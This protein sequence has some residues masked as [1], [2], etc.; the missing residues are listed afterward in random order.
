MTRPLFRIIFWVT[1]IVV[2]NACT[3]NHER[4]PGLK[5]E[6]GKEARFLI[7]GANALYPLA[8]IWA[9]AYQAEH[10]A[11]R[12]TVFPASSTKGITD[13]RMGLAEIGMYSNPLTDLSDDSLIV[14]K[15]AKDAVIPTMNSRNPDMVV[16]MNR[17]ITPDEF[18]DIFITGRI[19]QWDQ[20]TLSD[21]R[22]P[23]VV[24]TRSD[25]SGAAAVWAEFLGASQEK[26]SGIGVYGDAGM[27]QA[28]RS[29]EYAIGYDN[30]RFVYDNK[31][32][33]C[34]PGITPI[35]IDFNTNGIIE[36]TE[37]HFMDLETMKS[38]IRTDTYPYP[39]SRHLF[40]LV[41]PAQDNP[42][43]RDF[44]L[45]VMNEGRALIDLAGYVDISEEELMAEKSKLSHWI[46]HRSNR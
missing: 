14:L 19:S 1:L 36:D 17:G 2:L 33:R 32:G 42:N 39:L 35:P 46:N 18:K 25:A 27:T 45:W 7:H 28:I 11:V 34:Y 26:L 3:Q 43:V 37:A 10:P 13:V 16:L 20:L 8:Q 12:I 15:V 44:L 38:S 40:F 24:F 29:N 21:T 5:T 41:D 31:S 23:V 9:D 6:P 30:L 22:K 4:K